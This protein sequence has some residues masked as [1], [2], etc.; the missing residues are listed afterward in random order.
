MGKYIL[1]ITGASGVIYGL[2]LLEELLAA[3]N[4]VHLI[5]SKT[6][7]QVLAHELAGEWRQFLVRHGQNTHLREHDI[8]DLFA[9]VASGSY[10]VD[11]MAVAPC[12][13]ATL[14]EIATGCAK[15]LLT[16]AADVSLKER[17]PLVLVPREMPLNSIHLEN[18]VRVDRAGATILPAMPSFYGGPQTV[19]ALVN[20]VV[21]RVLDHLQIENN[22]Y[23]RW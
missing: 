12:S 11:G 8:Q 6:G 18:M 10:V 17:R 14:A 21:G 2:R 1:G 20:T 3:E 23:K 4:T 16:R 15:N 5:I 22:L 13:M 19:A 7:R 9:S